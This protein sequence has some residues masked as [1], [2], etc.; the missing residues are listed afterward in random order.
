MSPYRTQ[1][2]DTDEKSDRLLF[3]LYGQLTP[4]ERIRMVWDL[5]QACDGRACIGI[6]QRYP[7]ATEREVELRLA[8]LKYGRDLMVRVFAWDPEERGW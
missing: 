6:R 4:V 7:D 1:A 8:A 3:E 2:A 5:G